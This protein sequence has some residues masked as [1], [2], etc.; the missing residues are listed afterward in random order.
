M[1]SLIWNWTP[2]ISGL[3]L[4][5][6]GYLQWSGRFKQWADPK[7]EAINGYFLGPDAAGNLTM[8]AIMSLLGAGI[9]LSKVPGTLPT[10]EDWTPMT[11]PWL[12]ILAGIVALLGV[13]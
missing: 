12:Y 6:W 5:G 11:T 10:T 9:L 7:R 13:F 3:V 4:A 2:F 1:E 8:E